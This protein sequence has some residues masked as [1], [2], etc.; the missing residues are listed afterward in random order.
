M[1][2]VLTESTISGRDVVLIPCLL[3]IFLHGYE[4][5]SGSGL[6]TRLIIA[7]VFTATYGTF[8]NAIHGTNESLKLV[9]ILIARTAKLYSVL[10]SLAMMSRVHNTNFFFPWSVT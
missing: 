9:H 2:D 5:K 7:T 4:I 10:F 1:Y 8:W 3:P 6:G